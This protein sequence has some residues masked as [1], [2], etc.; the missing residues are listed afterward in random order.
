MKI[1]GSGGELL[2][3]LVAKCLNLRGGDRIGSLGAEGFFY[4]AVADISAHDFPT[5]LQRGIP[6][7]G[8]DR[9]E[10][11]GFPP[12]RREEAA[13]SNFGLTLFVHTPSEA[14]R[15]DLLSMFTT[16]AVE[17]SHPP[18]ARIRRTFE[19]TAVFSLFSSHIFPL[20]FSQMASLLRC[21]LQAIRSISR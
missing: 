13:L 19:Q 21:S 14:F 1:D 3:E 11:D 5:G 20:E 7:V 2:S 4:P 12:F 15:S 9:F 18:N 6:I 17:V 8:Q 10:R 16:V